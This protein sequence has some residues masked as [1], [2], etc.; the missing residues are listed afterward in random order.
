M[1]AKKNIFFSC[2]CVKCFKSAK[3]D[4]KNV[5]LK[6]LTKEDTFG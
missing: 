6:L 4:I 1:P 3:K 5:N 2:V